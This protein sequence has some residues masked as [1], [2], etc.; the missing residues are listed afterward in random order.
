MKVPRKKG[1]KSLYMSSHF[2]FYFQCGE[3]ILCKYHMGVAT[4][5][6]QRENKLEIWNNDY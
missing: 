6:V 4:R 2:C 5:D 3:S 1:F